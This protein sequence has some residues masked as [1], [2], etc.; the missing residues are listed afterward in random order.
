L[1][2]GRTQLNVDL[3]SYARGDYESGGGPG[4]DL[5]LAAGVGW[6]WRKG[7]GAEPRTNL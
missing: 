6:P 5:R 4:D 1:R 2:D 7:T 3:E